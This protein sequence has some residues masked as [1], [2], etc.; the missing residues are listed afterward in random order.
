MVD[1]NRKIIP[2]WVLETSE[3]D[4]EARSVS[5]SFP[6]GSILHG[7][8]LASPLYDG[9]GEA[10]AYAKSNGLDES[11]SRTLPGR[12]GGVFPLIG[13]GSGNLSR[14]MVASASSVEGE[15]PIRDKSYWFVEEMNPMVRDLLGRNVLG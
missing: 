2:L 5:V 6:F 10:I 9:V 14:Y 3:V 15:A 11:G 8:K 7:I 12:E 4:L 1:G 13:R